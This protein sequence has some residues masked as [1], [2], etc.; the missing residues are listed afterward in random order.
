MVVETI[1]FGT[2]PRVAWILQ[3]TQFCLSRP[4]RAKDLSEDSERALSDF[5]NASTKTGSS[6]SNNLVIYVAKGSNAGDAE[7][8]P[9]AVKNGGGPPEPAAEHSASFEEIDGEE[10]EKKEKEEA[11]VSGESG[12]E[13]DGEGAEASSGENAEGAD[14][15]PADRADGEEGSVGEEDKSAENKSSEEEGAHSAEE[16][17]PDAGPADDEGADAH[18]PAPKAAGKRNVLTCVLLQDFTETVFQ[19]N[20]C[21]FLNTSQDKIDMQSVDTNVEYGYLPAGSSLLSLSQMLSCIYMPVIQNAISTKGSS[22]LAQGTSQDSA[23]HELLSALARFSSQVDHTVQQLLGDIHLNIPSV[24]DKQLYVALDEYDDELVPRL[25]SCIGEW[26]TVVKSATQR[27]QDKV[28]MGSGPLAEIE[29]WRERNATL[30]S[31]YEQLNLPKTQKMVSVVE[32]FSGDSNIV[33]SF[34]THTAELGKVYVEAKDNVKFLATLERHFK[35]LANGTLLQILDTLTPMTNALRTVWVISRHYS[36]D[37]KMGN[38]MEKIANQIAD[39][40]ESEIN[41]RN[42]FKK[43]AMIALQEIELSKSVLDSWQQVYLQVREKIEVSGRDARWEFDRKK[44]FSRTSYVSEVCG[45]LKHVVEVVDEFHKFLGPELK[46]VTGDAQAIDEVTSKVH[47]MIKPLETIDFNVF[48][49]FCM[50]QWKNMFAKFLSDKEHIE[51]ATKTFIDSSFKKLRSAE[52]AV[53][54]LKN[55]QNIRGQGTINKQMTQKVTDIMDQF[56][57][58]ITLSRSM[59]NKNLRDPPVSRNQPPVSGAIQWSR[60]LFK[61]VRNTML[62]LNQVDKSLIEQSKNHEVQQLYISFAKAVMH[63]ENELF[64]RW[65][66]SVEASAMHNLKQTI[67]RKDSDGNVFVNFHPDLRRLI[68]ETRYLDRMGF[69]IPETALN[70]ALQEEKYHA[71]VEGINAML[72]AYTQIR[73]SLTKVENELL[74]E[75]LASLDQVLTPG[76]RSLNWNSLGIPDFLTLCNKAMNEFNSLLH[77]V[78]KNSSIIE[79]VVNSIEEQDLISE[80]IFGQAKEK[81]DLQEFYELVERHRL[82]IIDELVRK[83]KTIPPLLGKVEEAIAGTNT[84]RSDQLASYYLHWERAIFNALTKMTLKSLVSFQK[85]LNKSIQSSMEKDPYKT[86]P[87]PLFKIIAILVQ[88]EIVIHPPMVD[89]SKL[90][91]KLVNNLARCSKAFTRW[92]HNTCMET[93]PQYPSGSEDEEPVVFS[94]NLDISKNH[95]VNKLISTINDTISNSVSQVTRYIESWRKHQHIWKLDKNNVLDKFVSKNPVTLDF[96]KKLEEYCKTAEVIKQEPKVAQCAFIQVS[97]DLL[98]DSIIKEAENWVKATIN[99]MTDIDKKRIDEIGKYIEDMNAKLEETPTKLDDLKEMLSDISTIIS[100]SLQMELDILGLE[101][102]YRTRMLNAPTKKVFDEGVASVEIDHEGCN[103]KNGD[104]SYLR[105]AWFKLVDKAVDVDEK[106]EGVKEEFTE[107]TKEQVKEFATTGEKFLGELKDKY[108]GDPTIDLDEGLRLMEEYKQKLSDMTGE[109]DQLA[110][111]EKLFDLPITSYPDL[112]SAELEIK[113]LDQV[114]QL[115]EYHKKRV[116]GFSSMLWSELDIDR[117]LASTEETIHQTKVMSKKI[118][119]LPIF[120]VVEQNIQSFQSSLPLIQNLKNDALRQRH[121]E[122]LMKMTGKTFDMDPKTFTLENLFSMELHNFADQIS[123]ITNAATKELT[124]ESELKKVGDVWKDQKFTLAKYMKNGEERGWV[125]RATEEIILLL[126]DMSLNLQS[127]MASRFVRPF[128]DDVSFWEKRLSLIGE[129]IEVWMVVQRKWMYLES[130]F[131]GSD[132]IRLQLPQEA[133]RFDGIDKTWKK[134]MSDTAKNTN[135]LDACSVEGRLK[136]LQ[137][138]SEQLE[139]CQKCLSEYLDTKRNAFPRFFFISDDELLSILGT[140]DPSSV[141]EHMLKLF[142]NCAKLN[143]GRGN[144]NVVGMTSSEGEKFDFRTVVQAEGAVEVW[145][146]SVET[147]MKESLCEIAK[148]SVFFYVETKRTKWIKD[149][150]GMMTLLGS[151]VWWTWEVEDVFN[152]VRDGNKYAMKDFSGKLTNQLVDL[153]GM[154]RSDLTKEER[155]KVNQLI[156]IDVHARDIIDV[157][158]RDSVLDVREF[159][160]ESQLRFNWDRKIDDVVI[161]QCT[162]EFR[163]GYEYMGLNGRLV[164]TALTDR[165]YMTITTA[166]TYRLGGAP[167]GPAGTGKTETVKDLAKGMALLCVVFNCGEGLDYKA[168]GSIFSGLVQCGAWGCFDEFNRIDAEVLSVVSS[169]IKQIQ[170]ALKNDLTRFQFEGKEISCDSRTGIFITMNPG[171]AGRTELPDNLKALFRPVTMI[172]PDLQQICEIMLFSE[173]FDT[174][175]VLAK[176]MTVLYKLAKEQL[177]KQHHYDFGLRALKSV[178]VIAGSLKRGSPDL[179]EQLVLMRALRDMNLP[180]FVFDD[181]PLFLGLIGDLFPGMDCPRVRYPEFNDVVENDL[182]EHGYQVLTAASEQVDKVIQLYEI[183][184]TRHTTMVVGETGGGKSVIINTL[185]RSQTKLGKKTTLNIVNPKAQ[186]VAELYGVLDPDTRDWTDG[187]LSNL[188]RE[189]NKPLTQGKDEARYVVFD[190]D[191]DAVWVENMNSV[192]DDNKLLTLPNGERIRLQPWCKLLFEVFDLQYASPATISR[193]GMVYVDPRNLGYWPYLKTWVNMAPYLENEEHRGLMM[194]LLEKYVDPL[195]SFI[196]DGIEPKAEGDEEDVIVARPKLSTPRTNLNVVQQLTNLIDSLF[197]ESMEGEESDVKADDKGSAAI[198]GDLQVLESLFLTCLTWSFGVSMPRSTA[199]DERSRFDSIV[200]KVAGLQSSDQP[201]VPCSQVPSQ[202]LYDYFFDVKK[203]SWVSWKSLVPEYD[204]TEDVKFSKVLIPTV[205]TVRSTWLLS[206]TMG[207]GKSCLFVGEPGTAKSVT[208]AGY[209]ASMDS[210]S[211][212]VLN[213]NF[214]SR[215]SSMDVQRAVEDC[216]EKRTKDTYGPPM[217]KKLT[218]FLDDMNMPRVDTYGTQQPIALL[219]MLIDRRGLYDRGKELNWKNI[220]DLKFVGAMGPPG[221]ARNPVDPRY[222]SLFNVFEIEFPSQDSLERIYENILSKQLATIDAELLPWSK[223]FTGMTLELYS[224]IVEK[225][226]PTPKRFHYVFNLRDLSRIYQGLLLSTPDKFPSASEL[227]RLWRNEALRV[228]HDRLISDDDRQLVTSKIE[229]LVQTNSGGINVEKVLA[230]PILLGDFRNVPKDVDEDEEEGEEKEEVVV[231]RIYEDLESFENIKTIF[232]KLLVEYNEQPSNKGSKMRLVFFEDALE[233]LTR[234]MRTIRLS[235]GHMLLVGV[236]GSGK[237]SLATLAAYAA[238]CDT[239]SITLTR[240]YDENMFRE[241]LKKLYGI[242]QN[243]PCVFLFTD[244]NVVDEGFLELINNML[245]SG[246]VPA[247]YADDEKDAIIR[248]I[249]DEVTAAGHL[250]TKEGCWA[251][252]TEKC[253]ENLHIVLAMSPVGDTLR[254]RCRNFPGM[255]N[256]AVIDWF[257]PWPAEALR[258]VASVF[259]ASEDI[260][261]E[262]KEQIVEHMVFVHQSVRTKSAQFAEELRR[263]NYVTPKNYLDFIATYRKLLGDNR[264]SIGELADRLNGGLQK[265]IQAASEVDAMQVDLTEAKQ[266]VDKATKECNE[267]LGVISVSTE[268]VETKQQ[269]AVAKEEELKISSE[270]IA[271]EKQEAEEALEEAIPALEE[272]AA[273]LNNLKKEDITEIRYFANPHILVQQ[274]CECVVILR[275]FKDV[276]WKGAKAMMA[277]PRFLASLIEFDKDGITDR[278]VRSVLS[279]MKNEKFNPDEVM[280]IS[281]AGAGLLKWVYAMINYNSVAKEVNPKRQKVNE[282][283]KSLRMATKELTK[284]KQEVGKLNEQLQ[285][286]SSQFEEKTAEQQQLKEKADTMERRLEAASRLIAGLG[287]ERSRWT[288]EMAELDSSREKLIGDCLLAGSFLSYLGAFN[289]EYRASLVYELWQ[290][291]IKEKSLPCSQ[292]FRLEDI[293]TSEVETTQ[294]A[295]EGLPGDELSIQNGILTTRSSRFPLCIDP[296]MQA[297]TWIKKKEGKELE[298]K[299]KTFNDSDFLKKLELAITYGG[300]FLFE[301]LDEY[302]DPVI[303]PVLNKQLVPNES[304]KLC[305]TLGENEIEW[306]E[307]FRL[308]MTSKLSNPSYGPEVGGKTSIINYSVTQQGLQ[309][310]LLNVTVRHERLDLEERR[311]ELIKDMSQNKALLKKLE[312]TLLHELSNATGNILDNEEL[313]NTLEETKLKATEIA[314]KLEK[315]KETAEEIDVVR[316]RYTPAAKRG[317]VLFFVMDSLSAI[318]NMYEYSLA[319]FLTVFDGSLAKSKKDSNLD[320][321]LRNIIEAL[322]FNVYNYTCLGLFEKHKL[323]FSFQMTI[324]LLEADGKLNRKQLDFF[325]KGNLSLEK[326]DRQKPYDW[327]PDQGWEDLVQLAEQHKD[328]KPST[329]I[330]AKDVEEVHPLATIL[331]SVEKNEKAWKE[332]YNFEAPE[333]EKLPEDLTYRLNIFEQLLLL[334]CFRV[335]RVTVGVTKYVIEKM[336]EKY[337]L[338]PVLDYARIYDQSTAMTP[339]IF[340]LSPGAD[341]AFDVFKLGEEMGFKPGA[342]LKYMA[343]GQGMGPKAQE[344]IETGSSRGLWIMLQNCHL[345][346]SWLKTLEKILE[347]IDKPHKDFR[348]WLTTEPTDKFPLGILQRSLKVVTEPPN[349]LKLNMRSSYS[350]IT[351]E[352]LEE[353]PHEAFRPLVYALAFF[354]A[355]VQERRKYGKLGWNV[356]YD[357]NETDFRISLAL[358]STYLTKASENSSGESVIP[359]GTLRYLIGEAMYGGR[360]SDSFDRRILTTYLDEY[361]GDFLFDTFQSFHFYM[362]RGVDYSIPKRGDHSRYVAAIDTLPIVQT[363]EVFGLHP[364]ADISYYT[365]ATKRLW[366]DLIDLQPRVGGG[367]GEISREDFVSNVASDL[368]SKV[369]KPFDLQAIKRSNKDTIAPTFVVLLQEIE[370]WNKLVTFMSI[371]LKDLQRALIGEIGFSAQLEAI[372]DSLYNGQLPDAWRRMTPQTEK[373]LG[374]WVTWF[375]RRRAQYDD[376]IQNGEPKVIWLSGFHTPETFLAAL[377]QT[378]CRMKGWALDRSTLYTEVTKITDSKD[379]KEK[380]E[381]GCYV[382]GLFLEGAAWDLR[383]SCLVR[384]PPKQLVQELPILRIIPVEASKLKLS[385]CFKTPVYITQARRSAMG[386]GLVME[387]DL[388]S[389]EHASHWTLQGVALCLNIDT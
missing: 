11:A 298:G 295:S 10:F 103:V 179:D 18:R 178:L 124:I 60:S 21:Y 161:R 356:A 354:H 217:G 386:T 2:D 371:T 190:G 299:V 349:G 192:M 79:G 243:K 107:I 303:D 335:D 292:P 200:K 48:D 184:M 204:S 80:E 39:R 277:D 333:D 81:I 9:G 165:C 228:L 164:I 218:I 288:S 167:A 278:Q 155:K 22:L 286:L 109:K 275:G 49:R 13:K 34:K 166:L 202:T 106:L 52:G 151:Q 140:S 331:D 262:K 64:Q 383:K 269:V 254:T 74:R 257:E 122:Q 233:H 20:C 270:K 326:S 211:N 285:E 341:P 191:V 281:T 36:D 67:L 70:I 47:M 355:V 83:Y 195:I 144:K 188:F 316:S 58:E 246:M 125:L 75:R 50:S 350:K 137:D 94:Y 332:Y 51:Q 123:E 12:E 17:V 321:R 271:I 44:L 347:K 130:I 77:Q 213:M 319:A 215:T 378:A 239:F 171:Y 147:Q 266:V 126:E 127:M 222:I 138:L 302:I 116:G 325:L 276:S 159:A 301:N 324:K 112:N 305:I 183:M 65:S 68:S 274:V 330:K 8:V 358:I 311:E 14:D 353:C 307:S 240:G 234:I 193:C 5:L 328:M 101:E 236:S 182:K 29:Y 318:L 289:Y 113:N 185:A 374:S 145:M 348:L 362:G 32:K 255:V 322:T 382:E 163:Y 387:A 268:E 186:S 242:L 346:P 42:L 304:G 375:L 220:R 317:A 364:N 24:P 133:K 177:S 117:V 73:S 235:Q 90:L 111:A 78:H 343:L 174:A 231:P 91:G 62:T 264:Q 280:Q 232:E 314:E 237:Q 279:Y 206:I 35:C 142:D 3:K 226:P 385:N 367:G 45:D 26:S 344:F 84:G 373:K 152:R 216:V 146:D 131:V 154:V 28:P 250:D 203:K 260:S 229:E 102:R 360:V 334:R 40:V 339:V 244:S 357:F 180:K 247:L 129:A 309:A 352:T 336:S 221:G 7:G 327:I 389:A 297:I 173:G 30:S 267:L 370:R 342:K 170:E 283:E 201:V 176:K 369:P 197:H 95:E 38:L 56:A 114:Y 158:I 71:Y 315:A 87:Q 135:V 323:M 63:Y 153:T 76:F 388:A 82:T 359:W 33:M 300:P 310:Q 162:G 381:F 208:I 384:Q 139:T 366:F 92:M 187:L 189:M 258:S 241:D 287:S 105:P 59:F 256:N 136:A 53:D 57:R 27:D 134:I 214:S 128:L 98:A 272:A 86:G 291:D 261:D 85:I 207:Q 168:M 308:Y 120:R 194:N 156:I 320:V 143:F 345:L 43:P 212:I 104:P 15:K 245:T 4:V 118:G 210:S 196:F 169:Q 248:S 312:D 377:V 198:L 115:Y 249:R 259:L 340:V 110:F 313:I 205:D 219:K 132:D 294:W 160:W 96:D 293:L 338:P 150:L 46:A 329:D 99:T 223:K 230:T 121:W 149:N 54:L 172:V 380:P 282:A 251:Y 199:A 337:V 6:Q 361:M 376:W 372:S 41:V 238:G 363:P 225:L 72:K 89:V 296:Q 61:R 181:V 19:D 273:A 263:N 66:E 265:L 108:P 97:C 37:N 141:Q 290:D 284:I 351:E 23:N 209:L 119:G 69:T 227:M 93:P 379:I 31:L 224:T 175:K 306:D 1:D 55:F 88:P 368:L 157:F 253:K 252:Y 25:E 365:N 100:S 16:E 148:E